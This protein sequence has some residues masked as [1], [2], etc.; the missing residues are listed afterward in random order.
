MRALQFTLRG[1]LPVLLGVL[2]AWTVNGQE[3]APEAPPSQAAATE[4]EATD[5][6]LPAP[7]SASEESQ[8]P[9]RERFAP[10]EHVPVGDAVSF[11]VDI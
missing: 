9:P 5:S 10:S 1:L 2:L 4:A 7:P 6:E 11:P 3:P 8:A